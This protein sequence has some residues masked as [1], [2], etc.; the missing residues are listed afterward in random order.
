LKDEVELTICST[1][2]AIMLFCLKPTTINDSAIRFYVR[3]TSL[4]Q[5]FKL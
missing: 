4:C 1:L 3:L 2:S 5:C